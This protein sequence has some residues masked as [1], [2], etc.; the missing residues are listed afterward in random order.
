MI[1]TGENKLTLQELYDLY[2]DKEFVIGHLMPL[3][4][5]KVVTINDRL[6]VWHNGAC[7]INGMKDVKF[8]HGTDIKQVMKE[9]ELTKEKL[10]EFDRK[11]RK[12][13]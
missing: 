2:K 7:I 11:R 8:F 4:S 10:I 12:V 6:V 13:L 1:S 9:M 5:P 3:V